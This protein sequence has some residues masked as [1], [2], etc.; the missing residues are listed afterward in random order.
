[1]AT[2]AALRSLMLIEEGRVCIKDANPDTGRVLATIEGKTGSYIVW[3]NHGEW[4]CTCE[5]ASFGNRCY[6]VG[7][8]QL[9]VP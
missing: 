9:V 2:E 8:V 5:A 7:A 1:M 4:H 6:H 3:R